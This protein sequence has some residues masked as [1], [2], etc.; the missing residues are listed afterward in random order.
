MNS[1]KYGVHHPTANDFVVV[2][3]IDVPQ[4]HGNDSLGAYN[5]KQNHQNL[6]KLGDKMV[7]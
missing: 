3:P 4:V 7:K 6:T 1:F 5:F 2:V